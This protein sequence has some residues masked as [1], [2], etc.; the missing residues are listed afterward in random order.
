MVRKYVLLMRNSSLNC[1]K[2]KGVTS[3]NYIISASSDI[4]IKK[5]TNQDSLSV[6]VYNT[7]IGKLTFAVLCDGMGGLDM[8]EIASA[9]V[10]TAFIDWIYRNLQYM[11]ENSIEDAFIRREWENLAYDMNDKLRLY[12][13]KNGVKLGT[14]LTVILITENRYYLCNIGDTRA[15]EITTHAVQL[16]E[17]QT[18]V[19]REINL[20]ILTPEQAKTD[21]RRNVLLQCIGASEI[22]SPAMYFG[23]TKK[24]AVYMLCTDGFRHEIT[25][26]EI[27]Y[28]LNPYVMCETKQMKENIDYLIDLNKQRFEQDNISAIAIRTF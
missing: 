17:D 24:D 7:P 3:L 6:K 15:Y 19:Q 21:A 8:G 23:E 1:I 11:V 4:G 27:H 25:N 16:T 22:I 28:W 26:E 9:T 14:T 20:G 5:N 12:G 10:V 18:V 13:E 2:A